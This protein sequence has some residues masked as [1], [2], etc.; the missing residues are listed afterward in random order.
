MSSKT[1]NSSRM[2]K[3]LII[4]ATSAIAR[5]AA[6]CFAADGASLFL[7]GRNAGR[8]EAV[9]ADLRARGAAR[10]ETFV[11]DVR[12][13]ARHPAMIESALAALG[14]LDAALLAHGVLPDQA[15]CEAD[16]GLALDAFATNASSVVSLCTL[17]SNELERRRAGCLAVIGSV[18]GDRVRRSNYVYGSA[19][20]AV[21]GFL[22]G[23]RGRLWRSGVAV[24]MIKPGWVDTPMTA[25]LRK[26]PLFA[27]PRRVG[28]GVYRAMRRGRAVVYLP[29][30]WYW[31]LLAVRALP[32]GI[33]KRLRF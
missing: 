18:A 3:V 6:R 30:F 29:W 20:A 33:F 7:V 4:G 15:A 23:L 19:K 8:L 17:L 5:E 22:S 21:E 9:A 16:A 14:G 13:T 11:L 26:N 31:I 25:G 27:S 2:D 10:A 32:E 24:V 12:E 1:R 28:R